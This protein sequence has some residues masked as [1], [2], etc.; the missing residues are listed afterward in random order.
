MILEPFN[1]G[2][3]W[4]P[5]IKKFIE[6][7]LSLSIRFSF[8][9][10]YERVLGMFGSIILAELLFFISAHSGDQFFMGSVIWTQIGSQNDFLISLNWLE[11]AII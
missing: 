8:S 9:S 11:R 10:L 7:F 1:E 5:L 3:Y 6:S 2:S 4:A